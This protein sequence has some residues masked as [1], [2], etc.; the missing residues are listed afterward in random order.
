M[1]QLRTWQ[2]KTGG[3]V[4][5]FECPYY[6]E[7]LPSNSPIGRLTR[8]FECHS[9]WN[10]FGAAMAAIERAKKNLVMD[11]ELS[12]VWNQEVAKQLFIS[13]AN[14]HGVQPSKMSRFWSI[15]DRQRIA[16]G[17]GDDLPEEFKFRMWGN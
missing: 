9:L 1:P 12:I 13:I 6:T 15:M 7:L 14:V 17:G 10:Y 11:D 4:V 16:L 5:T 8:D 3:I 2:T